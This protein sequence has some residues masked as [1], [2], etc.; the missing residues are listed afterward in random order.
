MGQGYQPWW[1][2][3]EH[4]SVVQIAACLVLA[5]GSIAVWT[6][7]A[8]QDHPGPRDC[9]ARWVLCGGNECKVSGR[10]D[11]VSGSLVYLNMGHWWV[12]GG[13]G[14]PGTLVVDWGSWVTGIWSSH[15]AGSPFVVALRCKCGSLTLGDHPAR[16]TGCCPG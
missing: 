4:P 16:A 5:A 9:K 14:V 12:R 8:G 15:V 10:E 1:L 11:L 13:A 3:Q 2:G 7:W 6:P